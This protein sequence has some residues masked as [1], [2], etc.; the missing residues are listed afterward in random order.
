M[1]RDLALYVVRYYSALMTPEERLAAL[2]LIV[3]FHQT[4]GRSDIA[5]QEEVRRKGGTLAQR[6]SDDPAVL[7]WRPPG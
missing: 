5:A 6:M 3:T 7:Q 2:R 1:D 4:R